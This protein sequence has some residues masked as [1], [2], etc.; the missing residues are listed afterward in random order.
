MSKQLNIWHPTNG[1]KYYIEAIKKEK[2][3]W[4]CGPAGSGKSSTAVKCAIRCLCDK[5]N[6]IEK[7]LITRPYVGAD[8]DIG[9][10][11][12]KLESKMS[13]YTR[14]IIDEMIVHGWS[15]KEIN[16]K[17]CE[18]IIEVVPITF[19]RGRNFHNSFVIVDELQ[20]CKMS[21]ILLD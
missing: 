3:V 7:I 11:P 14:P 12:G 20:N 17:L 2:V 15:T 18:K 5:N 10:L 1:Q 9:F 8:V 13:P 4:C 16:E 6:P 21:Q 19:A